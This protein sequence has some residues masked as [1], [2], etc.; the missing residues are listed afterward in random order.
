MFASKLPNRNITSQ[1][2]DLASVVLVGHLKTMLVKM[3]V[4]CV[5]VTAVNFMPGWPTIKVVLC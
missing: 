3:L 1:I 2:V 4:L 5:S